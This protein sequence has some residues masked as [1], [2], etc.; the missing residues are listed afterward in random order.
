MNKNMNKNKNRD[1]QVE[2]AVFDLDGAS[3]MS[4]AYTIEHLGRKLGGVQDIY[5]DAKTKTI[6]V[7]YDSETGGESLKTIPEIVRR[8]GYNASLRVEEDGETGTD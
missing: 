4:C 6:R 7:Q 3:C 5:V 1:E 8:I 2:S